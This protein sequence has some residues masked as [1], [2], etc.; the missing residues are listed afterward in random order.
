MRSVGIIGYGSF[1]ALLESLTTKFAPETE[2]RIFSSRRAPDGKQ[3]FSFEEVATCDVVIPTVPIHAFEDTLTKLLPLMRPEGILV[4]VATVKVHTV[5]ILRRLAAG[6]PYIA[7]HPMF[8]PESYAKRDNDVA[9]FR[10]VLTEST[11][12]EQNR[13]QLVEFL[14]VCGFSVVEMSPEAHDKHLAETL[15]LTHLV[16]QI[17]AR[18]EFGRTEI[19]TVSFGYLMDAVESVKHDTAL[20]QDVFR[21][22]PYCAEVLER[23]G[24]AEREVQSLLEAN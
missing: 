23:F 4:D 15:F 5:E 11:I 17:I 9:G 19:D 22:N 20:F 18:G 3:F 21:Y 16:G 10:I 8:G 2:V 7:T 13:V 6:R 12:P 24:I 14:R 1:G